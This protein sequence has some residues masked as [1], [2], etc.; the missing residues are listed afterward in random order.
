MWNLPI[1]DG[2][3]LSASAGALSFVGG[4]GDFDTTGRI[5]H[6]GDLDR[7]IDGAMTN[8]A[9]ALATESCT[10]DDV[11]RLKAHYTAERDDWEVIAALARFFKVDYSATIWK[12]GARQSG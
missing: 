9:D 7:Q 3:H 5:R 8:V 4:A 6:L 1:A 12:R 2:H 11:L 10:L